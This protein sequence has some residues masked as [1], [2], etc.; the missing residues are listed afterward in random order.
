MLVFLLRCKVL[1]GS[2][3][4]LFL[5]VPIGLA[6][7]TA[8]RPGRTPVLVELF[9]S[10]GCS[11]CPPADALLMKLEA[12]Q[13]IDGVEII[14]LGEHVDY[15]DQLGWHDRFS[16]RQYTQRQ[17]GYGNRFSLQ[18]VYTP[19]MVVDGTQEFVGNDANRATRAINQAAKSA[20]V[21]LKLSSPMIEGK[22]MSL[23][24]SLTTP[25]AFCLRLIYLRL[26][27]IRWPPLM[28]GTGRTEGGSCTT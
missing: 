23:E 5:L 18:G 6:A 7:Q 4:T 25:G 10:E 12:G 16:S 9:T 17:N 14:A 22:H 21:G 2:L 11:S 20:K 15:W 27:S 26:L 1:A 8:T 24:V 28:F 3:A 19:Q 13:P